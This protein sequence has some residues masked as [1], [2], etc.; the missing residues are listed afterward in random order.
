MIAIAADG[1]KLLD[2]HFDPYSTIARKQ[3]LFA[4]G[5]DQWVTREV[6]AFHGNT[7]DVVNKL[8]LAEA[9]SPAKG[10]AQATETVVM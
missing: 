4:A 8:T 9:R 3:C 1:N 2:S 7:S 10:N 5:C 6:T